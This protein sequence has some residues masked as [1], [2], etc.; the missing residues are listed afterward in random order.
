MKQET[1]L[2]LKAYELLDRVTPLTRDC[3]RLCLKKCCKGD[4]KTGML[5][6]PGEEEIL[7]DNEDFNIIETTGNFGY[8]MVVCGGKCDRRLRP[9][10]CRIYPYFP[11]ITGDGYD[12]RADI[13][14]VTSCPILYDSIKPDY[15]FIRQI[16][17]VARLFDRNDKL[18]EYIININNMLDDLSDFVERTT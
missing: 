14:G 4:D 5:L 9:L 1:Q 12:V 7:K 10:A 11:M 16:R 6:F 8:K 2:I 17:K 3:G 18:R 13:R 15:A